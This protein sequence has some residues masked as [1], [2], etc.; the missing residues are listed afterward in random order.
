V[1]AKGI[2]KIWLNS[3][4]FRSLW[5]VPLFI[6]GLVIILFIVIGDSKIIACNWESRD[7]WECSKPIEQQS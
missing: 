7:R 2:Y 6:I 1:N 5:I 4:P 3:K